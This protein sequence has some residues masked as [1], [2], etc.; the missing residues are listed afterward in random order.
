LHRFCLILG[1]GST[2]GSGY[3]LKSDQ[4]GFKLKDKELPYDKNFFEK[5]KISKDK[6]PALK[7]LK[8]PNLSLKSLE[9]TWSLIDLAFKFRNGEIDISKNKWNDFLNRYGMRNDLG[10]C[11]K[12]WYDFEIFLNKKEYDYR[13]NNRRAVFNKDSVE[14]SPHFFTG[15]VGRELRMLVSRV[16]S[17]LIP[18]KE[19]Q[20]VFRKMFR[21]M[22]E[23]KLSFDIVNFNYDTLVERNLELP[24][25]Y[26]S[27]HGF[28][29]PISD[30]LVRVIKLH[31][32]LSWLESGSGLPVIF[33]P[34][35]VD[36]QYKKDFWYRQP[37]IVPPTATKDEVKGVRSNSIRVII[38]QQWSYARE[39]LTKADKLIFVGYS[40]PD[41]D[42]HAK[43]LFS[44]S[45]A[46]LSTDKIFVCDKNSGKKYIN[47]VR[48]DLGGKKIPKRNFFLNGFKKFVNS[49][50][51]KEIVE[52][53]TKVKEGE[54]E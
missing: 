3:Q 15:D 36:P 4:N 37:A 53:K 43:E 7:L 2:A 10:K 9:R 45:L 39:M 6:F 29:R 16:Y 28:E 54:K 31:G 1:S 12:S 18:P 38:R 48:K 13:R 32:S 30:D 17:N 44:V 42:G 34:N 35:E 33:L 51:K 25:T 40:F 24:Y 11:F 5:V 26:I 47:K 27:P 19:E 8:H 50:L 23:N 41:T 49:S 20:N 46:H 14:S 22:K 52:I 21:I